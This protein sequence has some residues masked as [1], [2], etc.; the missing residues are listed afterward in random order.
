[1]STHDSEVVT[2]A[3]TQTVDSPQ[4]V[5]SVIGWKVWILWALGP[6]ESLSRCEIGAVRGPLVTITPSSCNE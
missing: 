1:M 6:H 2:Q 4:V 3:L 5:A